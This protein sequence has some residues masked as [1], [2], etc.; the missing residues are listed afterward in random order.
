[1]KKH[2]S[3]AVLA[4]INENIQEIA[5]NFRKSDLGGKQYRRLSSEPDKIFEEHEEEEDKSIYQEKGNPEQKLANSPI[6]PKF[7]RPIIAE[8]DRHQ[9]SEVRRLDRFVMKPIEIKPI[10]R[11]G[12]Q[13]IDYRNS[14]M[15]RN[16]SKT[17]IT[18]S[19]YGVDCCGYGRNGESTKQTCSLI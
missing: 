12:N 1:M 5:D 9:K 19:G 11:R 13:H 15:N 3:H 6:L 16:E 14:Q 7:E 17:S 18:S 8:E 4:T 10:I 2:S